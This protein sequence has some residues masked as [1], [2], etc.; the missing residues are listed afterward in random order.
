MFVIGTMFG[1]VSRCSSEDGFG[2]SLIV[3]ERL[4]AGLP[5]IDI[6]DVLLAAKAIKFIIKYYYC[7]GRKERSS[8]KY[9]KI[10]IQEP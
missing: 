5:G 8:Q 1:R 3:F 10:I 7:Q 9:R 4:G 2:Y 6:S